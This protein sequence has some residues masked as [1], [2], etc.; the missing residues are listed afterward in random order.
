M[1]ISNKSCI[2]LLMI[3]SLVRLKAFLNILIRSTEM[4]RKVKIHRDGSKSSKRSNKVANNTEKWQE[5][6][7][8]LENY[9]KNT[10]KTLK[11]AGGIQRH[12]GS[13]RF[14]K[15]NYG[16]R[17]QSYISSSKSQSKVKLS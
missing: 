11:T 14:K 16:A 3:T 17:K 5:D 2:K 4:G 6:F 1:T 13:E 10:L 12:A 9:V 7:K 8:I 15:K